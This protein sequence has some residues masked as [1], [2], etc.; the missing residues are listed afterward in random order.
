MTKIVGSGHRYGASGRSSG[1]ENRNSVAPA[2]REWSQT[3]PPCDSTIE[4]QIGRP[5]P[6]PSSFEVARGS[7]KRSACSVIDPGTV[8]P[9]ADLDARRRGQLTSDDANVAVRSTCLADRLDCVSNQIEHDL[10]QLN[11]VAVDGRKIIGCVQLDMNVFRGR[12]RTYQRQRFFQHASRA[13]GADMR[14][15][16]T[17]KIAHVAHHRRRR[18]RYG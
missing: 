13:D 10:F 2:S 12:L 6:S 4:T 15:A 14:A 1:S 8:V 11:T 9:N 17:E 18:D 3:R 5:S 7:N 16:A